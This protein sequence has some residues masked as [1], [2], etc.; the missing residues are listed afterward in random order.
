MQGVG[1]VFS[2]QFNW[3]PSYS[4]A[5]IPERIKSYPAYW[6]VLTERVPPEKG[7]PHLRDV[8]ISNV[9]ASN[10]RVAFSV[11]SYKDSPLLNVHFKNIEVS[12]KSAGSIQNALGWKFENV[13]I[14][15]ADGSTVS[16]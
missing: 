13:H 1:S 4:Y 16:P 15:T 5:S 14:R 9:K 7:L 3:N 2:I 8:Q 12:A 11:G 10:A 6:K